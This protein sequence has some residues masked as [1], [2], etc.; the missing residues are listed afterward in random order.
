VPVWHQWELELPA[1]DSI[2]YA[3]GDQPGKQSQEVASTHKKRL[4]SDHHILLIGTVAPRHFEQKSEVRPKAGKPRC[5]FGAAL[6]QRID[7]LESA[8][9]C[10]LGPRIVMVRAG[11][12]TAGS[13]T[14]A[15]KSLPV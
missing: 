14:T 5:F 3:A 1:R 6:W 13:L 2:V 12:A 4:P 8:L 9:R 10:G 15:C 7:M 11:Y